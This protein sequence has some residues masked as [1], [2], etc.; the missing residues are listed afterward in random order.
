M[1]M[2]RIQ[3]KKRRLAQLKQI[4]EPFNNMYELIAKYIDMRVVSF[5][6]VASGNK[7]TANIMPDDIDNNDVAHISDSASAAL[8]GALW[9]D[10]ANSFR[11]N[12]HR[13]IANIVEIKNFFKNI[14]N[15]VML[16]TMDNPESGLL[17]ALEEGL[18]ELMNFGVASVY[19]KENDEFS[20]PM[21]YTCWDIKNNYIDENADGFIDTMYRVKQMDVRTVVQ[22]YG[23]DNVSKKIKELYTKD[24]FEDNVNVLIT[25]EPRPTDEQ[26]G[27]GNTSM[28]IEVLHIDMDNNKVMR[29][30]GFPDFPVPTARF[31]KKPGEVWAR[32][33]GGHALPEVIELN[34]IW[35][36][37][38]IAYEKFLD[39]PL[40]ML[41]D[42]RLG[43]D[44]IDSSAGALNV[45]NVDTLTANAN[46]VFPIT[47]TSEPKGAL[48]LA[49][50]LTQSISQH[51]LLDRLLD[52][53]NQTE[54]TL[55]EA[56]IR[57]RLRSDSLRRIYA[58][59][60]A[61]LFIPIINRTF[62]VLF[63]RGYFGVIP[64]STQE[65]DF[66]LSGRKYTYLPE[67]IIEAIVQDVEFYEIEFISPAA[68]M[69]Q[70]EEA[71]GITS[72]L[73]VITE[74]SATVPTV[75][76][77]FNIDDMVT[78]LASILGVSV[79][80]VNSTD[81][82][83]AIR[84]SRAAITAEAAATQQA[85]DASEIARNNSQAVASIQNSGA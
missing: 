1:S 38:T 83:Q 65:L 29:E 9:P 68:R 20:K 61:E 25:V 37:I 16:D 59:T 76:D 13:T 62:N 55:G 12:K 79:D 75:M 6:D 11:I 60:T 7:T 81:T 47:I 4:K 64:G 18:S 26:L 32:G 39:P 77:Q 71:N 49:Q 22:E 69:L 19:G 21:S 51:Y 43:A 2:S 46:P 82:V 56:N 44:D 85:K 33:S 34:V 17:L 31:K 10:G 14:V 3:K 30:S 54:M 80:V 57:D 28:P 72:I 45:F 23:L 42:G 52:L 5:T 70:T 35:E 24:Q 73:T 15:P 41:D 67:A 63:R 78:R 50:Q 48:L 66:L 74:L 8:F 40:G 53:N 58:R 84:E 36:A 27:S